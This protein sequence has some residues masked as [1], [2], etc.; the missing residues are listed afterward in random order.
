MSAATP[1]LLFGQ[2]RQLQNIDSIY[3]EVVL[4]KHPGIINAFYIPIKLEVKQVFGA[5]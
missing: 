2:S 1:S 3:S 4:Y 5:N